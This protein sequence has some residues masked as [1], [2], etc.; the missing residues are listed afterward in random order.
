M[1]MKT[2]TCQKCQSKKL[3]GYICDN[4]SKFVKG[5]IPIIIEFDCGHRLV[6]TTKHFCSDE[7]VIEW[8]KKEAIKD[9]ED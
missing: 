6:G 7:C 5:W 4:C 1:V 8:L 9:G 2:E 3:I